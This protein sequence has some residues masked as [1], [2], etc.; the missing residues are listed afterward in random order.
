M[1]KLEN[2]SISRF[3]TRVLVTN[4]PLILP[5]LAAT[6]HLPQ[7]RHGLS[8]PEPNPRPKQGKAGNL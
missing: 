5:D 4:C 1:K 7:S 3:G 8:A 2:V 6:A